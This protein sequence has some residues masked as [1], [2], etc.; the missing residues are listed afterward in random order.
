MNVTPLLALGKHTRYA[1]PEHMPEFAAGSWPEAVDCDCSGFVDWCLGVF[2]G[3]KV[4][5]PLYE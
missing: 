5:H 4:N 1:S 3:R 2:P